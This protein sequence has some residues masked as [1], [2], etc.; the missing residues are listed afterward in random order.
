MGGGVMFITKVDRICLYELI[1]KKHSVSTLELQ[2]K[3]SQFRPKW[4]FH[5]TL[6]GNTIKIE[7]IFK[8]VWQVIIRW[9]VNQKKN[10]LIH[11]NE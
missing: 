6:K 8:I 11:L 5:L 9:A 4:T 2:S 1:I 3:A 10:K 7:Y